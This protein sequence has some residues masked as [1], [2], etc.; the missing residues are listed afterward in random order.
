MKI[1][2]L[3]LQNWLI[4]SMAGLLGI[5]LSCIGGMEYGTPEATFQVKGKVSAPD[6][7]PIPGIK[8]GMDW[9]NDTTDADGNYNLQ[10]VDFPDMPKKYTIAFNDID[11]ADNGLFADDS[12]DVQFL[13][14]DLSGGDGHWNEGSASKTLNVTLQPKE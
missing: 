9:T 3:K 14:S 6:G 8:V 12:V 5:N 1:K 4:I 7:N 2:Y 13:R 11:S 10:R